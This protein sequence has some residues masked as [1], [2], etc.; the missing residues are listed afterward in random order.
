VG[1][2][3]QEFSLALALVSGL[4]IQLDP[5]RCC[6]AVDL[7]LSADGSVN[8]YVHLDMRAMFSFGPSY[9]W[10]IVVGPNKDKFDPR[11]FGGKSQQGVLRS[12]CHS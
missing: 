12:P 9:R 4:L 3:V 8:G 2:R 6:S 10:R 11:D 1:G 5:S 7:R